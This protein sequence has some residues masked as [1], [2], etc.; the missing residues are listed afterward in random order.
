[1]QMDEN[2]DILVS[3]FKQISK[4]L[5]PK[6]KYKYHRPDYA[7][8]DLKDTRCDY[9][10]IELSKD[11]K[12]GVFLTVHHSDSAILNI[13]SRTLPLFSILFGPVQ[14]VHFMEN[15]PKV[16]IESFV[17]NWVNL[18]EIGQDGTFREYHHFPKNEYRLSLHPENSTDTE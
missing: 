4:I 18:I 2:N 6:W 8:L 7:P 10:T 16:I 13:T 1:M 12:E 14:H 17:D 3:Q 9:Q 15:E 5:G 11:S